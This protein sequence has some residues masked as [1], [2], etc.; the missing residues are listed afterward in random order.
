MI[1]AF[2]SKRATPNP[3]ISNS[4]RYP[5]ISQTVRFA[6]VVASRGVLANGMSGVGVWSGAA[7]PSIRVRRIV[8]ARRTA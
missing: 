3:A 4:A 2:A 6:V 7:L 5:L 8:F 1:A